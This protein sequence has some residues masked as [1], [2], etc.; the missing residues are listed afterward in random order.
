MGVDAIKPKTAASMGK[1]V[2]AKK[3]EPVKLEAA[4]VPPEAKKPCEGFDVLKKKIMSV[5]GRFVAHKPLVSE[6]ADL[7][8]MSRGSARSLRPTQARGPRRLPKPPSSRRPTSTAPIAAA[9]R[10]SRT[11]R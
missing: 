4:Y 9:A 2:E 3:A 1:P 7:K 8:E 6:R 10:R 5:S 11:G